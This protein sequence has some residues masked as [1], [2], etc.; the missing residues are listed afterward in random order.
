MTSPQ[1]VRTN[2]FFRRI[3][4]TGWSKSP[5]FT[6]SSRYSIM[7][8]WLISQLSARHRRILSI[9]CGSGE[10]EGEMVKLGRQ[11]TGM[12]ICFEMLQ[13]ARKRGVKDVVQADALALPFA[14]SSFDLVMFPE[15]IGYFE[16]PEVL[17]GVARVLR[18]RGDMLMTAYPTNFAS[19]RIYKNRSVEQL[20]REL[21][22]TGFQV[23][24]QKLLIVKRKSVKQIF[25]EDRSQIIYILARK[26]SFPQ[27]QVNGQQRD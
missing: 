8:R 10:L 14:S 12:D 4:L 16:L 1:A 21:R 23:A 19:D 5:Y 11:V 9:G 6:F 13:L 22:E 7:R 15:S 27:A 18:P 25:S 3:A 24:N 2:R 26:T 17:P 20:T